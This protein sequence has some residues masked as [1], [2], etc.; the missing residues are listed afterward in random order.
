MALRETHVEIDFISDTS[1]LRDIQR[2]SNSVLREMQ[3]LNREFDLQGARMSDLSSESKAMMRAMQQDWR[4]QRMNANKYRDELVKIRYGYHELNKSAMDYNGSTRRFMREVQ[5]LGKM[6]KKVTDQMLAQNERQKMSMLVQVGTL[7]NMST[8]A[9]KIFAN[10]RRMGNPFYLVNA[11]ALGVAHNLNKI[12]LAGAPAAMALK[13]LGPTANMK[14]L[15]DMTM[16]IS[17]GL[18]RFQMVALGAIVTNVLLMRGLHNAAVKTVPGYEKAFN[19]MAATVRKAFQP[20]VDVFGMVMIPIYRFITAVANLVIQFNKA[21][22]TIAKMIQGMMLLAVVLTLVLSPLAIG[23][24]L[25]AGF[26]AAFAS[27]WMFIG[28]VV[29]GLA[30]MSGTVWVVAGAIVA[31][32]TGIGI[33]WNKNK[34]FRDGVIG[35]WEAIRAKALQVFGW[36]GKFLAPIFESI[37]QNVKQFVKNVKEIFSGDFSHIGDIFKQLLPSIIGFLVGGLPGL[38][39]AASRFIPT[40]VQGIQSHAG[41]IA[42][43]ATKLINDFVTFITTNLPRLVTQGIQIITTIVQGIVQA[44]P[45]VISAVTQLLSFIVSTITTLLPVLVQAGAQILT[46]ILNAIIQNLPTLIQAGIQILNALIQGIITLLPMLLNAGMQII[47]GLLNAIVSA[48]PLILNAAIQI[49]MALVNG[50]ITLLPTLA[51]VAV[52]IIMAIV[53]ML[54]TNLPL[55]LNA[56]IQLITTL[57]QGLTQMIPMLVTAAVNLITQL[58]TAI[59]TQMPTIIQAG[60]TIITSLITGILNM[61]PQLIG[62]AIELVVAIVNAL[63]QNGPQLLSAGVQLITALLNGITQMRKA[64]LSAIIDIGSSIIDSILSIDLSSAGADMMSGFLNGISSMGDSILKK[65]ESIAT[66]AMGVIK[67]ALGIASPSKELFKIGAWTSEGMAL[68]MEHKQTMVMQASDSL[69]SA[70]MYSPAQT[71]SN[72]R[73]QQSSNVTFAPVYNIQVS[74]GGEES[75]NIKQQ[76]DAHTS[77]MFATLTDLFGT[78]VAY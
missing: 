10:Y 24:G 13:L 25:F 5:A 39:I 77:D 20:M 41:Q 55:I 35:A 6:Q 14:Q 69:A 46:A 61:L 7:L 15:R 28:P 34:A 67:G 78:E 31:L 66:G 8:Q 70:A 40:I 37:T 73:S 19:T 47:M 17:Q 42:T 68:G 36:L 11:G 33:L 21:H 71:V 43:T 57:I 52:Q 48:L 64:V 30:A 76:L 49:L 60:V 75:G 63:I 59:T 45:G 44:L 4:M 29:T 32:A 62:A 3:Y 26:Q 58:T 53:N 27:L 65:A 72:S 56:G 18:M 9:E 1:G 38:L 54:I 23:I 16:M 22:P 51:P 2:E 74:G 50:I 12:A